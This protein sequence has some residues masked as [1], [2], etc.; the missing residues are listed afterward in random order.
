MSTLS[1]EQE[2]VLSILRDNGVDTDLLR[3]AQRDPAFLQT[4]QSLKLKLA[5]ALIVSVQAS[6]PS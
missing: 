6:A 4:L 2:V 1:A 3:D 5:K